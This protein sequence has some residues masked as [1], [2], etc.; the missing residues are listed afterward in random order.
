MNLSD[1]PWAIGWAYGML[2]ALGVVMALTTIRLLRG[3]SLPDRVVAMDLL[4]IAA[5][6]VSAL[7]ALVYEQPALI[8]LAVLLA[9]T[10]FISTAAFAWYLERSKP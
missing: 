6:A 4:V 9:L 1:Y 5:V 3:P 8:D 2:A 7:L 10:A